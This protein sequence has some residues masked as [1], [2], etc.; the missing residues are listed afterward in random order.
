MRQK[1]E[2]FAK[3]ANNAKVEVGKEIG[4]LKAS[5]IDINGMNLEINTHSSGV[6]KQLKILQESGESSASCS[7]F[8]Q[9]K[10]N[11]LMALMNNVNSL[12]NLLVKNVQ[13]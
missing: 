4:V 8:S 12:S 7:D 9:D 6:L 5:L 13:R 10:K 11:Q 1:N 3:E 2:K